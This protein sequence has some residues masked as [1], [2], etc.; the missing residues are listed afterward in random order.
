MNLDLAII[1][2]KVYID[3]EFRFVDLGIKDEKFAVISEPGMI[4]NYKE[5]IDAQGKYVI[6]GGIDTHVHFRDPGHSE[7][8]TFYTESQAAVAGGNTTI[9]EHPISSPPQ[10]NKKILDNRKKVAK[11][12]QGI[13]DYAFFGAAGGQYPE[14]I[15]KLAEEGIVAF[16]TFLH[17][18][19]EGRDDEFRGLTMANDYEILIGMKEVAKTGLPLG[20]HAENNDLIQGFI[21]HYRDEG[22]TSPEYHCKSRPPIS[23]YSTV[24]KMIL[25]AKETGCVLDL[26]HIS[27]PEAMQ[28]AKEAKE[29]GQKLFLETCP[30]FLLLNEDALLEHG[31]YA[32]CNP[33]LRPQETVDKLWEYVLDGTVDYIGSD[34]AP[35]LKSEKEKN[36]EDI[37]V[38]PAGFVGIDLRIPLLINEAVSGKR[39][40]TLERVVELCCE[41]PAKAF[42]I[43]PQKG[44]IQPGSDADLA[45]FSVDEETIVDWKNNYSGSK[46]IA[47]VYDGW[48][49]NCKMNY[50][51]IRGKV[52]M[53]DGKVDPIADGTKGWGKLVKANLNKK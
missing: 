47:R 34:H 14:E 46:E 7:R 31:A 24:Q 49:L 22:K 53:K 36:S 41:N 48:K 2:G 19:P 20:S 16:K 21:K 23:E 8:G 39:G 32:K 1:N 30:H 4:K 26:V 17:E 40:L 11:E 38:A 50:T 15:T 5:V 6:P 28:M 51:I 42:N 12:R 9:L 27:T 25:F 18:A 29:E 3:G 43:Y 52:V 13:V 35:F 44:I 10:Y 33:P 37:F 45:I